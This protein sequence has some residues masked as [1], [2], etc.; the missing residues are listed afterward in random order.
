MEESSQVQ[1]EQSA[2]DSLMQWF[3][4]LTTFE[5]FALVLAV[6]CLLV[7]LVRFFGVYA[8]EA[9]SEILSALD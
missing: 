9:L 7:I 4:T 5:I 3:S 2:M 8:L 1:V 6:V